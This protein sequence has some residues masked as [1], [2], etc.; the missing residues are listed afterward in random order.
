MPQVEQGYDADEDA[1]DR[2]FGLR[3]SGAS[4][5]AALD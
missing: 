4:M 3:R 1:S 5:V 2:R